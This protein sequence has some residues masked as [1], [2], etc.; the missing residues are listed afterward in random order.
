MNGPTHYRAAE[1]FLRHSEKTLPGSAQ[2]AN[3]VARAQAHATLAL[4]AATAVG[5]NDMID[6]PSWS[7]VLEDQ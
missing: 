2:E 6:G 5:K 7:D 1:E 3:L 4:A